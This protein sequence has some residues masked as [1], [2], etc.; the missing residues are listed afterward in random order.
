MFRKNLDPRL[1]T[2][3]GERDEKEDVQ[4]EAS[5]STSEPVLATPEKLDTVTAAFKRAPLLIKRKP[6]RKRT[7][8]PKRVCGQYFLDLGQADF[9]HT[10]CPSCGL[11]YA[12]GQESDEKLHTAFHKS[13]LQGI[14]FKVRIPSWISL[15]ITLGM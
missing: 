8:A 7:I 9:T 11:V 15:M 10:T 13:Q 12:R 3:V 4:I 6:D 2:P 14:R 1:D 5:P